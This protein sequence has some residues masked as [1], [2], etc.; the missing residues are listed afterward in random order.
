MPKLK[1]FHS[2]LWLPGQFGLV[3]F[4]AMQVFEEIGIDL[5]LD[6]G[7]RIRLGVRPN[8]LAS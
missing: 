3:D 2:G 7:G 4:L 1:M 8:G 5:V 6:A